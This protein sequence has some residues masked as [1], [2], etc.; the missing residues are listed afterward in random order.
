[1]GSRAFDW[2]GDELAELSGMSRIEARGTLRLLLK[3]LGLDPATV[4]ATQLHVVV[5]RLLAPALEKRKVERADEL[6]RALAAELARLPA[7][8]AADGAYEVFARL[9]ADT[10]KKRR[11]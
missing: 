9:E 8:H 5:L 10:G 11:P 7:E 2:L 1:M 6:A 4:T 3:D